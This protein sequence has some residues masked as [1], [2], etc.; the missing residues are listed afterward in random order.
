VTPLGSNNWPSTL[1]ETI[2]SVEGRGFSAGLVARNGVV[3][4]AADII[5]FMKG[6]NGR[7]VVYYCRKKGWKWERVVTLDSEKS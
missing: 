4:E 5:K 1:R 6:W 3:V 7:Q 2:I